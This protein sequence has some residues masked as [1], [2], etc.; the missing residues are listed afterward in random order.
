MKTAFLFIN[1]YLF[2]ADQY[3]DGESLFNLSE[4]EIEEM[5]QPLGLRKKIMR[6]ISTQHEVQLITGLHRLHALLV[7][8]Y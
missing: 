5:V 7:Y 8:T 2:G 6:L 4:S 1:F 3:V